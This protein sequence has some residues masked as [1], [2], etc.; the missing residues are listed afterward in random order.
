MTAS[1]RQ[2]FIPEI[3]EQDVP[4]ALSG[5]GVFHQPI[6][7]E[8]ISLLAIL[9]FTHHSRWSP[10]GVS[11]VEVLLLFITANSRAVMHVV[12]TQFACHNN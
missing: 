5:L 12:N 2:S 9:V 1:S 11:T 3:G 6:K 8:P 7:L 4:S 10:C